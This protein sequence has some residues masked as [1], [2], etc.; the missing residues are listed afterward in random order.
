MHVT[1]P[2]TPRRRA[3]AW[4]RRARCDASSDRQKGLTLGSANHYHRPRLITW[5][6]L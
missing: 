2:R 4:R 6:V 3:A 5:S 1:Q